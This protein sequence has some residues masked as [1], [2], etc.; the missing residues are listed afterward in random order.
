MKLLKTVRN[1]VFYLGIYLIVQVLVISLCGIINFNNI[2][3][4]DEFNDFINSYVYLLTGISAIFT[5]IIY[6]IV[7]KIKKRNLIKICKFNKI[8][9]KDVIC[10]TLISLGIAT[11]SC[12]LVSILKD[13][14][15]YNVGEN[16][17]NSN[18][19]FFTLF[20]TIIVLPIFEEILFR[21]LIFNELRSKYNVVAAVIIQGLIFGVMHGNVIQGIYTV[22]LG[23]ILALIYIW[24]NSIYACIIG[25]ITYNLLGTL[26]VP[27]ML[28]NEKI[29]YL[30]MIIGIII[31]GVCCNLIYKN[32]KKLAIEG[33][34]DGI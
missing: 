3:S 15:E 32:R 5:L 19:I 10:T 31:I 24:T 14:F 22:I 25:H 28:I 1:L 18:N 8:E 21:G 23:I 34:R 7:L 9:I 16:L 26:V 11:L 12:S 20:I 27:N 17:S 4:A 2:Q 6:T 33:V 13:K 29:I 30:S